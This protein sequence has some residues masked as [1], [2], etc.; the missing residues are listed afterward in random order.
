M[1]VPKPFCG[2]PYNFRVAKSRLVV[3]EKCELVLRED[4]CIRLRLEFGPNFCQF[5]FEELC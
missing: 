1:V 4:V 5:R 2:A 3:I